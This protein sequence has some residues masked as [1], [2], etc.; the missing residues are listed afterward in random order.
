[1]IKIL[2]IWS[3]TSIKIKSQKK[4]KEEV[5]GIILMI[6]TIPIKLKKSQMLSILK[7]LTRPM[8]LRYSKV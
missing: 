8:D 3:K 5:I 4:R 1:M 7:G 6:S 2:K